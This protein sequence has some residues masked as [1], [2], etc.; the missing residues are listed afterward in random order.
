[1][2]DFPYDE[3]KTQYIYIY[4]YIYI[5]IYIYIYTHTQVCTAGYNSYLLAS[6]FIS[7]EVIV[8]ARPNP[9]LE[10]CNTGKM[11]PFHILILP[12][13]QS[14]KERGWACRGGGTQPTNLILSKGRHFADL[15]EVRKSPVAPWRHYRWRF[16]MMFP[17]VGAALGLLYPVTR[18]VLWRWLVSLTQIFYIFFFKIPGT[19]GSPLKF[20]TTGTSCVTTIN[21]L[22]TL[23][24]WVGWNFLF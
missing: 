24:C 8:M 4:I 9:I 15:A 7:A 1:M 2:L 5:C 23:L 19:F 22:Q 18:G 14:R 13:E 6:D 10:L 3:C 20:H 21:S 16:F 11:P 12:S 17:A